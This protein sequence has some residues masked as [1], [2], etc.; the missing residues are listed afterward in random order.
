VVNRVILPSAELHSLCLKVTGCH[1][2]IS[3][4]QCPTM[5]AMLFYWLLVFIDTWW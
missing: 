5:Q 4:E 3:V 2:C 1:P